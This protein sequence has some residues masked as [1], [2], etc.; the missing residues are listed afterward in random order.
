MQLVHGLRSHQGL[1]LPEELRE[2]LEARR[3]AIVSDL[4]GEDGLTQTRRDLLARYLDLV[5]LADWQ[6]A[7]LAR[8]GLM[9]AKGRARALFSAFLS[10]TDRQVKLAQL[11]GLERRER[12]IESLSDYLDALGSPDA[13]SGGDQ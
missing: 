7:E 2:A 11:L 3:R 12:H 4:G 13:S 10:T 5:A 9:T 1:A 6:A 8:G